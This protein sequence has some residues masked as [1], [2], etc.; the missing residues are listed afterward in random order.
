MLV[1]IVVAAF[2]VSSWA[3]VLHFAAH[4]FIA[5]WKRAHPAPPASI[6]EVI[7]ASS[8][9]GEAARRL[10]EAAG[11]GAPGGSF[12][13]AQQ[14]PPLGYALGQAYG[15]LPWWTR[16]SGATAGRV[17]LSIFYSLGGGLL[18]QLSDASGGGQSA[19]W[20]GVRSAHGAYG[21]A[22]KGVGAAPPRARRRGRSL[23]ECEAPEAPEEMN[24]K[25]AVYRVWTSFSSAAGQARP[26]GWIPGFVLP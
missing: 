2:I 16:Y 10:M 18:G 12:L 19:P 23:A 26:P 8:G 13:A 21:A 17:A 24:F 1:L 5:E 6:E 3:W 25:T 15:S 22:A 11:A 7:G 4:E 20:E 9:S 14:P